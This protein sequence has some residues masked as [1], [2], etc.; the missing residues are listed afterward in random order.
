MACAAK[1]SVLRF[2]MNPSRRFVTA[3]KCFCLERLLTAAL[4]VAIGS[5]GSRA[6]DFEGPIWIFLGFEKRESGF[7]E[8]LV[9][10]VLESGERIDEA[11]ERER[12]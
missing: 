3:E 2:S 9:S 11:E 12:I 7:A 1:R 8:T 4:D 10:G 5:E 6:A